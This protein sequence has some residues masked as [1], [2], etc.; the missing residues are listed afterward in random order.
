MTIPWKGD[1]TPT[2]PTSLTAQARLA[3]LAVLYVAADVLDN[4]TKRVERLG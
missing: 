1:G 4:V 2:R 3:V